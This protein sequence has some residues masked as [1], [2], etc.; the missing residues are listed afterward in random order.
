MCGPSNR[1]LPVPA[2]E[3]FPGLGPTQS[4]K[5]PW[6]LVY[7]SEPYSQVW[8][9]LPQE[10][11]R[12]IRRSDSFVEWEVRDTMIFFLFEGSVLDHW[13]PKVP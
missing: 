1:P 5:P 13:T 7:K 3:L 6:H 2:E 9:M 10:L 4:C 12:S 11:R 8:G